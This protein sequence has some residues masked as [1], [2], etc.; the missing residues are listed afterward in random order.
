[1][2]V[3][4]KPRVYITIATFNENFVAKQKLERQQ[5][6]ITAPSAFHINQFSDRANKKQWIIFQNIFM[7]I[8]L[9]YVILIWPKKDGK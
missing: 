5:S 2:L 8:I 7:A 3:N 1:M 4:D 9:F 6:M